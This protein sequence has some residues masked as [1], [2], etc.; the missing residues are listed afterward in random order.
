[1]DLKIVTERCSHM[2]MN[3]LGFEN[4]DQVFNKTLEELNEVKQAFQMEDK[5]ALKEELGDLILSTFI[6]SNRLGVK[7]D[8][9]LK[10]AFEKLE[11]RYAR[12]IESASERKTDITALSYKERL[13]IW[14]EVKKRG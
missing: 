13:Q 12:F 9:A 14:D 3:G 5:Q 11:K 10:I 1:M 8:E 2:H 4:V 7:G 6:L